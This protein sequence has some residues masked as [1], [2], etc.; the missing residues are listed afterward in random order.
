MPCRVRRFSRSVRVARGRPSA[1]RKLSK[2]RAPK[3]ASRIT[4]K[5]QASDRMATV[6]A[7]EQLRSRTFGSVRTL[8][9]A[10][11]PA[12][13]PDFTPLA[14]VFLAGYGRRLIFRIAAVGMR[15]LIQAR[16][17][18]SSLPR[19]HA[20]HGENVF[21]RGVVHVAKAGE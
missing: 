19:R 11:V 2:R 6:R 13:V 3:N 8:A 14:P 4:R 10:F 15:S 18:A 20:M 7:T 9:P 1:E 5:V 16:G 17:A 21:D 12:L